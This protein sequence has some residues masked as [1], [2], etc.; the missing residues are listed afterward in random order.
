MIR[1]DAPFLPVAIALMAGIVGGEWLEGKV[2]VVAAV[3]TAVITAALLLR[4]HP[5]W[6]TATILACTLLL[7]LL[8]RIHHD[9]RASVQWP[10]APA[11][12]EAVVI[13]E[14]IEKDRTMTIDVQLIDSQRKV[15]C[16][17]VKS[18]DSRAITVGDGLLLTT[19]IH[20]IR[21]FPAQ[22]GS[23]HT[24][25]YH[26][27]MASR[28][29]T[30]TAYVRHGDWNW[31]TVSLGNLSRTERLRLH[32]MVYRHALLDHI[33]QWNLD[34]ATE[35]VVKA[36]TLGDRSVLAPEVRAT[37]TQTGVSHILALSGM[38]LAIIYFIIHLLMSWRRAELLSQAVIVATLWAYALLVGLSPS[39]TRSAF[40]ISVYALLSV[41]YRD[42]ASINTLSLT[43]IVMLLV[44]PLSLYDVSFQLSY[45][46]VCA[47]LLGNAL[48]RNVS[49]DPW[50]QSHRAAKWFW[51]ITIISL[52]AQIGT[53]PLAACHF[54]VF[55]PCALLANYFVI[56]MATLTIYLTLLALATSWWTGLS[57]VCAVVLS[58][59]V[60]AM[61]ALLQQ[62]STL[63]Y[64]HLEFEPLSTRQT[65]FIYLL[66]GFCIFLLI[67][68]LK[69]RVVIK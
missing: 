50:H 40:M 3:L 47:I 4:H 52:E 53:A 35:G 65:L 68:F 2:V 12:W 44:N 19:R 28:G 21:N 67:K 9:S 30:G 61:N 57:T 37:Y 29:F 62:V 49:P 24:F 27:F 6:Q 15:R 34:P 7:G 31:K 32:F 43:A 58:F 10:E 8:L 14:P 69:L 48:L 55:N 18:N 33:R 1:I 25:D 22:P 51:G 5:H 23:T 39:V 45:A 42:S 60:Q 41:G 36:M 11:V 13:D 46:A 20:D 64:S 17:I 38:H 54:G 26:R 56:P 16:H 66:L 59:V 63:P